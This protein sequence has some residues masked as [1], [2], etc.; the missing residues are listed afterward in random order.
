MIPSRLRQTLLGL[1]VLCG[2]MLCTQQAF[3]ITVQGTLYNN[4]RWTT[5]MS[6]V[7]V[8]GDLTIDKTATLTIDPGVVIQAASSD[9]QS[10][11]LDTKR[12]EIIVN[13]VLRAIGSSSSRIVFKGS[14][15]SKGVWYGIRVPTGGSAT[16]TYVTVSHA[17]TG[18]YCQGGTL[19]L[20][21]M[22]IHNCSENGLYVTSGKADLA[23]AKVY[24]NR[25][26]VYTSGGTTKVSD[27]VIYRNSSYGV[28]A[29]FTSSSRS[30]TVEF[31][32]IAYNSSYGLYTY[33]SSS[34]SGTV[35]LK[36]SIVARNSST[37]SSGYEVYSSNYGTSC[38]NNLIW[39]TAGG[40]TYSR[41]TPSCN[42]ASQY[43]PLFVNPS[44]NDYRIYDRSPAR[45][46]GTGGS[47]VGAH[48][49]ST[50][51]TAV[52]HGKLFTDLTL[53]SGKHNVPG[54]LVIAKGVRLILSPGA[55]LSFGSSDDMAGGVDKA[56]AEIVVEGQLVAQ[57]STTQRIKMQASSSTTT[58]SRW[59]GIRVPTGG[60]ADLQYVD[61]KNGR[62]CLDVY[63]KATLQ[64]TSLSYCN[65][66]AYVRSGS[67]TV[68]SSKIFRNSGYGVYATS[69]TTKLSYTQI[70][71]NSSYGVYAYYTSSSRSMTIDHCTIAYNSSY[72]VYTYRSRS[73]AGSVTLSNSIVVRNSSTSSSGYEVY[74]SNYGT[75]CSNNLIW[76]TAG[77]VTYSRYTPSCSSNVKF[78]PL[79]VNAGSDDYRIYDR[80]PARNVG[81]G[82]SDLGALDWNTGQ[83]VTGVW[84]GRIYKDTVVPAGT[85]SVVGDLIVAKGVTLTVSPGAILRFN[86]SDDMAG[87]VDTA[88]IELIVEGRLVAKGSSTQKINM[89][90]S[91]NSTSHSRWYGIRIQTGA[92]AD[93]DHANLKNARYGLDNYGTTSFTNSSASYNQYGAYVRSGSLTANSSKFFRNSGYGVYSTAGTTKL[94]YTQIYRNSSYGVYAYFTSSGRSMTID[95]C[96]IAYNS[97]YGVYTYRSSS[98][99]GSV[100]LS[101]SIVVRNSSTSSSGYEVYSSNYGTSC[102]NNLV[103][104]TAGGVTYSRYTPSCGI[105]MRYNPLFVNAGSDDYRIYDRSPA[106]KLGNN[107]SDAGALPWSEGKRVTNVLHGK[108]FTDLTLS[109]GTHALKGDLVVAKGV[110]LTLEQGAT[111]TGTSD[112]MYGGTDVSKGEIVVEGTLF[113]QGL[114]SA[115]KYV[116]FKG[117]GSTTSRNQWYG[118]RVQSGGT[119]QLR[120]VNIHSA[121]HG[122][123][124]Y[125]TTSLSDVTISYSGNN[126]VYVRSGAFT[127]VRGAVYR[128]GGY[129]IYATGGKTRLSFLRIYRNSSYGVYIYSTSSATT[130]WMDHLT[131]AYNSSYGV[132]NYRSRSSS[133][134]VELLNSIVVRNSSTS[135][136]GYE[137]YSSNYG[138]TCNRNLIWDTA[139]G[140]TYSRYSPSCSAYVRSNPLFVNEAQDNYQI[141]STSPARKKATDGTDLGALPFTPTLAQVLVSPSTSSLVVG[142]NVTFTAQGLDSVGGIVSGLTFTWK[143]VAGGGTINSSGV[144]TAGTKTGLFSSTIEATAK[145]VKGYATVTV[146]PGSVSKVVITPGSG[147]VKAGGSLTFSAKAY[148]AYNNVVPNSTVTWAASGGVGTINASGVLQ[149]ATKAGSYPG[150]ISAKVGNITGAAS[151]TITPSTLGKLVVSP[152]PGNVDPNKTLQFKA[153][154]FDNYN[155]PISNLSITWRIVNGGGTIDPTGLL[156]ANSKVATFANTVEASSGG[157]KGFATLVVGG[158]V[159]KV[160]SV[161][162]TPSSANLKFGDKQSFTARAKDNGGQTISGKSFTWSLVNGGGTFTTSSG[163][164][165]RADFVAGNK[166][167]TYTI[168]AVSDGVQGTATIVIKDPNSGVLDTI[169]VSPGNA[170]VKVNQSQQFT[171]Q[172]KDKLGKTVSITPT[173]T[174]TGG[175]TISTSGL[176]K[177]NTSTGTYTV[178][179][180]SGN[181]SGTATIQV[182]AGK[183]PTI[184]T[185]TSPADKAEVKANQPTLTLKNSTDPDG[186]KL[187]YEF[188]VASDAKFTSTVAGGLVNEAQNTT[189]WTVSKALT[190]DQTYYWRARAFDG[191][192]R[193]G[194][195]SVRSFRVNAVNSPPTA[196]KLSSPVDGGQVASTQPTLEVTNGSDPEGSKLEYV[197]EVATDKS[198][199]NVVVRSSKVKE[200]SGTTSWKVTTQLK[201]RTTYYWQAWATDDKGL[202]GA[203]MTVASFQVFLANKAP[204][205]PKPR[206]PKDGDTVTTLR[207]TFEVTNAT[208][209]DND[210]ITL[211]IEIDTKKTFDS[212]GKIDK[213]GLAQSG[214]GITSWTV[215]KDLKENETYYWRVRASDG[216]TTTSWIFGG[217]F[218]V[219][220]QNDKPTAPTP[221]S[222]TDQN[223][224]SDPNVTLVVDNA[225][226][227][228]GDTLTYHFQISEDK[229]FQG[230]VDEQQPITAGQNTTSWKSNN[231]D[232]GKTYYWRARANDGTNYGDWSTVYSFTIELGEV[233]TEPS[234]EPAEEPSA[235]PE[236][237]DEPVAEPVEDASTTPE[238]PVVEQGGTDE[239]QGNEP[240]S[241]PDETTSQPDNSETSDTGE[242]GGGCGCSTSPNRVPLIPIL[243]LLVA[244]VG[245]VSRRRKSREV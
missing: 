102:S 196:P 149:A 184:P 51:K 205:T 176:F 112:D 26:G 141:T 17:R 202:A 189:S 74:S 92:N 77:G 27:A 152:N 88:R 101:N 56:R 57:G 21:E 134:K 11:G 73:T 227:P 50:H 145:G 118:I 236:P 18:V 220:A 212:A 180:K 225:T 76:D 123:E 222:P 214:S 9:G 160:A 85:H 20:S 172:G 177:A 148:D 194:W 31:S 84:H 108:L 68:N 158:G 98:S 10:S 89:S 173:W 216:K 137:V 229:T 218:K 59:Y 95:H 3:A 131:V 116:T 4:T 187:K 223:T 191:V 129:G 140:T 81:T 208:D 139:G 58:H 99:S 80:S 47:D 117:T 211:D 43:N 167:G 245:F 119:A 72:G 181:I 82:G 6:P 166:A 207:P 24:S 231:L 8:N 232:R 54:D 49:W 40:I 164:K 199:S 113:A 2:A 32:T 126:G 157:V 60:D 69:G 39:D 127:F 25:Y 233:V 198:M 23:K 171:A 37:S 153:A 1:F 204:T 239:S 5:S 107:S 228:D 235:G 122:I 22:E 115:G 154:G 61:V 146:T 87:G 224:L 162:I 151:V 155:N 217:E 14:S 165:T 44:S 197:F 91:S 168:R 42:P 97:S 30:L 219:N 106:R 178:T 144:F 156:T 103:W 130:A 133:G 169:T 193:S 128:N 55:E 109:A 66:G 150:S 94:S 13:G 203:K 36:D 132:Y 159:A 230:Q 142:G 65:Y 135:S 53:P 175:G 90:D 124:T 7:I 19:D 111:V 234:V 190:E 78:N 188:E 213:V 186:D 147:S 185:L 200:G 41:Y 45:K 64:D 67:F 33:R 201:D 237:A 136:S 161:D 206:L 35:T 104:D 243:V 221:K 110:T 48:A 192:L 105:A 71:R 215:D 63:G 86:S 93:F 138:L 79:F 210:P 83:R 226:D 209:P 96:T 195:S 75:S 34:S 16:L 15:S 179:A 12:V 38:S 100:T 125:G 46:M 240:T 52:L 183:A 120:Y 163:L 242:G 70:Y 170:T 29:Y 241:K 244:L 143:V 238:E 121:R 62:Y 182:T 174:V 28:Y 114:G